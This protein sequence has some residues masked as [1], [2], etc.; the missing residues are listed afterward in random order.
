M[1]LG[2]ALICTFFL[3]CAESEEMS[4]PQTPCAMGDT[5]PPAVAV[6]DS[7][8]IHERVEEASRPRP[9]LQRSISLGYVGDQPLSGSVMR[10]TPMP[11]QTWDGPG[12]TWQQYIRNPAWGPSYVPQA[13]PAQL[14]AERQCYGGRCTVPQYY[15]Y[16]YR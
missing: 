10:D 13:P 12:Q 2:A 4:S 15:P 8:P 6:A 16:P 5:L 7:F 3:G 14:S 1:R 9:R 11:Q